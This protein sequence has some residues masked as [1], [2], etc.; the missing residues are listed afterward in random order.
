[1]NSQALATSLGHPQ[2]EL[3]EIRLPMR[4]PDH[5]AALGLAVSVVACR[6]SSIRI[7]CS[8]TFFC[9]RCSC[10][11]EAESLLC[12]AA[13]SI[14]ML[15]TS[16][17][18]RLASPRYVSATAACSAFSLRSGSSHASTD[19]A[20]TVSYRLCSR[21]LSSS[22]S[23]TIFPMFFVIAITSALYCST[24]SLSCFF[25]SWSFA[26]IAFFCCRSWLSSVFV[27]SSC[28]RLAISACWFFWNCS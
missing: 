22:L 8:T 10:S 18:N 19:S 28:C 4:M 6:R 17:W 20:G 21:A 23:S 13:T 12:S 24:S 7:V 3:F 26:R 1:M 5:S 14:A 2:A 25:S 15:D 9:K 11:A 16:D 27:C